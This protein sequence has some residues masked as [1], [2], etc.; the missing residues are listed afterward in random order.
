MVGRPTGKMTTVYKNAI[1]NK[2]LYVESTI[3]GFP[4]R[5]KFIDD[6]SSVN[7]MRL[8]TL[9]AINIDVKSLLRLMTISSFD[10]KDIIKSGKVTINFKIGSIQDQTCFHVIDAYVFYHLLI[11]RKI[12]HAQNIIQGY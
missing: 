2:S 7:L 12:L 3:N 9:K 1:H 6:G 8:S 4:N 11:G 10:N 5:K